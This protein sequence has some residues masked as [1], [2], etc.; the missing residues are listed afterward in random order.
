MII[1]T[2]LLQALN[3]VISQLKSLFKRTKMLTN[4]SSSN[5]TYIYNRCSK[6][7]IYSV[8]FLGVFMLEAE[9]NWHCE[10]EIWL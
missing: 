8:D 3:S 2:C 9:E 7:T 4:E 6:K 1:K 10:E 5:N